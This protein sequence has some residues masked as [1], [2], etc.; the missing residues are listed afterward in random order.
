MIHN[1]ITIK[2]LYIVFLITVFFILNVEWV[3][4]N[5]YYN[6]YNIT[7]KCKDNI[8]I[9]GQ[10]AEWLV[11]IYNQGSKVVE[12]TTIE[13]LDAINDSVIAKLRLPFYPQSSDRGNLIV[14]K[15]NEKVIVNLSGKLS[16]ANYQQ[17]LFYYPCFTT[18]VTDG[19]IIAR[20]GK[21]ESRHCYKENLTMPVIQCISDENCNN[22]EFCSSNA[23]INLNCNSCQYIKNHACF[24]YECCSSEQCNFNE[25]CKNN[26]CEKLNC[27]FD[28]YIENRTCKALNCNFD[29]YVVNQTCKKLDCSYDEFVFNNTCKKLDCKENE[30]IEEHKC[31]SLNCKENEYAEDHVC[32]ELKCLYNETVFNHTCAPLNCYFFQDIKNHACVNNKSVI[33][34]LILELAIIMAI[35]VFLILDIR[36]YEIRHKNLEDKKNKKIYK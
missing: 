19:Y 14:V 5:L 36:K 32:K 30:F 29:E 28:E 18:T 7:Y 11:T 25:V 13:L 33:F 26:A 23:C 24:D 10:R 31:K 1:K 22:N 6:I 3:N 9:E 35:I 2:T 17:N 20:Y 34:K 27:K 15:Q 4:A 8:C 21:Y 12:Y 16:G